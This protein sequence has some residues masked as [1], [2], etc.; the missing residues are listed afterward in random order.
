MSLS[1]T[2]YAR[3]TR[4]RSSHAKKNVSMGKRGGNTKQMG[5]KLNPLVL[6]F[7]S[8]EKQYIGQGKDYDPTLASGPGKNYKLSG[9]G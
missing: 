3:F 2:E 7:Y 8:T 6:P 1:D 5:R 4:V 9:G